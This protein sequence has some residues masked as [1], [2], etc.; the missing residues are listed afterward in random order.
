M[1]HARFAFADSVKQ[2]FGYGGR[3]PQILLLGCFT[4]MVCFA[5]QSLAADPPSQG[6]TTVKAAKPAQDQ[7]LKQ[8]ASFNPE[9]AATEKWLAEMA[10][11]RDDIEERRHSAIREQKSL[12]NEIVKTCGLSPE[13]VLPVL[14]AMEKERFALEIEF[15]LN[16]VRRDGLE[17]LCNEAE[18][19]AESRTY[20]DEVVKHLTK[21]VDMRATELAQVR[22]LHGS[23]AV[24]E[25]DV[26][27]AEADL[28]EAQIRAELR[29]EDLAKSPASAE[30]GRFARQFRDVS[31]DLTQDE[32]RLKILDVKLA[33]L[34]N[35]RELLD[36][37]NEFAEQE[38]P[39]LNRQLQELQT[40]ILHAQTGTP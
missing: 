24:S 18:K 36:R 22:K 17:R 12:R 27:K 19:R 11:Q 26:R 40:T 5:G 39:A 15:E 8:R 21:L 1:L 4:T 7:A 35:A 25:E 2:F 34:K 6:A 28:A 30:W 33:A 13:N 3:F 38:L 16:K 9:P 20:S 32:V 14:L 29:R 10:K 37:Y 23:N 31:L